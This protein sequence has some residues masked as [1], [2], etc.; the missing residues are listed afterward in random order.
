MARSVLLDLLLERQ[1]HDGVLPDVYDAVLA[2]KR[3]YGLHETRVAPRDALALRRDGERETVQELVKRRP[4]AVHATPS[5][6]GV[7]LPAL[8]NSLAQLEFVAGDFE[9]A[10]EHFDEVATQVTGSEQA[11]AHHNAYHAALELRDWPG[12]L[13]ALEHAV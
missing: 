12:A 7:A 10:K 5:L 4:D 13:A 3:R 11:V 2:L 1:R 8:L 6:Q 9:S